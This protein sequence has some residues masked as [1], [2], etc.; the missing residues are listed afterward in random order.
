MRLIPPVWMIL[1]IAAV[2][3]LDAFIPPITIITPPY[4]RIGFVLIAL[5][6]SIVATCFF[7]F[8]KHHTTIHPGHTP[9]TLLTTGIYRYSRNPIY[10]AMAIIIL[11]SCTAT[12][13]LVTF[14][15]IL[16]FVGII[17]SLFITHEEHTLTNEFGHAY[18]T[19]RQS[20]RRWI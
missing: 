13:N 12:G 17:T 16:I 2:I 18:T 4:S 11:G 6:L 15:I 8:R 14:P 1:S 3:A 20:T 9:T 5:G 19:Y 10:L 7:Q